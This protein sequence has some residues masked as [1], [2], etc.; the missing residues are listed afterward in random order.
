MDYLDSTVL[1]T[2]VCYS[3]SYWSR[4]CVV[5]RQ[6]FVFI[7]NYCYIALWALFNTLAVFCL[8]LLLLCSFIFV[9]I[10]IISYKFAHHFITFLLFCICFVYIF[11]DLYFLKFIHNQK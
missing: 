11:V 4:S 10:Y 5:E 3:N 9:H 7:Y 8:L 1:Y 2:C 6:C